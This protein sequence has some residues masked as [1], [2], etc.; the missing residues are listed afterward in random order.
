[1]MVGFRNPQFWEVLFVAPLILGWTC[2][3]KC[4]H[5]LT[6]GTIAVLLS[7]PLCQAANTS[8]GLEGLYVASPDIT[9]TASRHEVHYPQYRALHGRPG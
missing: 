8:I 3:V 9:D 4:N 6:D 5:C 2:W 1:M 7:F